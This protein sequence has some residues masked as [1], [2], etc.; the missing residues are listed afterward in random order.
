MEKRMLIFRSHPSLSALDCS[1]PPAPHLSAQKVLNLVLCTRIKR[2]SMYTR[3]G[4]MQVLGKTGGV[5]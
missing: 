2:S 5:P 4:L 1:K 3:S